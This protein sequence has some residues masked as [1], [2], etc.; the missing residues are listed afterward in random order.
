V[1]ISFWSLAYGLAVGEAG[2]PAGSGDATTV[3]VAAVALGIALVPFV[4]LI[5]TFVSKRVDAPLMVLAGM[6]LAIAVSLPLLAFRNPLASLIA[7]YA[8]GAVF[9]LSRPAGTSWRNRA[10]AAAGVAA[11]AVAGMEVAFIATAWLAPA[12]PFTAM[13][14]A[15]LFTARPIANVPVDEAG[16]D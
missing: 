11:F 7:G 3:S 6:G 12:M 4:F 1:T 14:L 5:A 2:T 10:F 16:Y 15:D 8:A 13:G 9:T